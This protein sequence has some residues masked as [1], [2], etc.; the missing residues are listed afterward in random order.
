MPRLPI[1]SALIAMGVSLAGCA[2]E[3]TGQVAAIV[4]GDEITLQEIN[5][6]LAALNLP[7]NVAPETARSLA[8]Q[9]V[10][11]RRLLANM[12]REDGLDQTPEFFIRQR[13]LIDTMLV[14]QMRQNLERGITTP[15]D[16]EISKYAESNPEA[17]ANRKILTVDQITFATSGRA[18]DLDGL[19]DDRTMNQVA[20]TLRQKGIE[21]RRGQSE[22][23]TAILG[24]SRLQQIRALPD[25]EPFILPGPRV[26]TIA[27]ILS[28]RE[29]ERDAEN[30]PAQVAERIKREE[31]AALL[32]QRL[33]AAKSAAEIEYQ[34]GFE[35]SQA[36]SRAGQ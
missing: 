21:F 18:S 4:N 30:F 11:D 20:D 23:D 9:R 17:F 24:A 13:Q 32:E 22:I 2:Q 25:G 28:E 5:G 10:I 34:D 35:P 8:L 15:S 12:A 16:E 26:T 7:Q 33:T 29:A 1:L 19:Q 3:P 27:V 36:P 14:D 6:E 31:L